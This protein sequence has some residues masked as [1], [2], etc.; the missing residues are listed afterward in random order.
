MSMSSLLMATAHGNRDWVGLPIFTSRTFFHTWAW[1]RSDA[2]IER[3][4]DLKGKRVGVPEYQQT[5]ALWSRGALKHEWGVEPEDLDW[6]MERPPER[7]HGGATGFR[8]PS[9]LRFQ[10]IPANKNIG[11]MLADGELDATLLYV[12]NT[13][14]VDRSRLQ[15]END[16]RF[17]RLF[18]D[19]HAEGRRY[20]AKT[21]LFPINHG[22]V[23]RRSIA[24]KHPWVVLNIFNAFQ[25]AKQ[26][27]LHHLRELAE[28]YLSLGWLPAEAQEGLGKDAFPYGV[29][30]NHK[31]LQ[32]IAEY[33]HEQGL[34]PRVVD[35]GE[36]FAPATIDL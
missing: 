8:P 4:E 11:S 30:S 19:V 23:V 9:G 26:P 3:P 14:L 6:Y 7:S 21:G 18:P 31:V 10:Y 5:A 34:T 12:A 17:R 15:L 27:S 28:P 1:V 36:V 2:G 22:M 25:Q 20:Y 32:T 13:N 24:E 29:K 35:L 33:S 16:A